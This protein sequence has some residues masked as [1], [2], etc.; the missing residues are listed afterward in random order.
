[1]QSPTLAFSA[2]RHL[3]RWTLRFYFRH[4]EVAGV[5]NVPQDGAVIF[6]GNHQNSLIDPMMIICFSGRTVRFAAADILFDN[7]VLGF[8]FRRLAAVPIRRRQDHGGASI[9]NSAAF[10][11]LFEVLRTGGAMG[12]F[13]EG[14]SQRE[15]DLAE[16]KTGPA[17]LALG[18]KSKHPE[19]RVY[20][21]PFGLHFTA[22][23]RFRSAA[24]LQLGNPIE[25]GGARI[26][27][28]KEA[29]REAV[30]ILTDDLEAAVRELTVTADD[31]ETIHTLDAAR[32]LYQ[33]EGISLEHRVELA[34]RFNRVFPGVKDEPDVAAFLVRMQRYMDMLSDLRLTDRE[35]RRFTDGKRRVLT[36]LKFGLSTVLLTPVALVG[37][38]LHAPLFAFIGW[39]GQ[40]FSPRTDVVGSTKVL[41]GL[42][43]TL[44]SY[45]A[46]AGGIFLLEGLQPAISVALCLPLLGWGFASWILRV[47]SI[48]RLS[49]L[50]AA[51]LVVG[52][53]LFNR[54]GG[55]RAD[56]RQELDGLITAYVPDDMERLF[57]PVEEREDTDSG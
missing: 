26:S 49:R 57:V 41:A 16:F 29:E 2:V 54:L 11:A 8:I 36:A 7:V 47:R 55:E 38:P 27:A 35:V 20:M 25:V 10:D 22:P 6:C 51:S 31:W 28:F 42:F 40:R 52:R 23:S 33:P 17:R 9:D 13:P 21:V 46:V 24:L 12:I 50:T 19:Q 44:M 4:I 30:G 43:L 5:D 14:I 48:M 1:M 53:G 45:G 15:S 37:A 39:G 18:A 34:R 32:R 56:L 3:A